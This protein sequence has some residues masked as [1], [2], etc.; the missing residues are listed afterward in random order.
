MPIKVLT[1]LIT[2][3]HLPDI[4]AFNVDNPDHQ[5]QFHRAQSRFTENFDYFIGT[6]TGGLIAFCL[7]I[8]YN[9]LDLIKIY[10]DAKH[11][12]KRNG[13][14]GPLIYSKYS[15]SVIHKKIDDIINDINFSGNRRISP[16]HA[17]LLDIRN[18]LNPGCPITAEEAASKIHQY[19]DCL[20]FADHADLQSQNEVHDLSNDSHEIQ[21]EKVLLITSYNTTNKM[22]EVF[23]TSY[24]KHWGYRIAG[25]NGE[26]DFAANSV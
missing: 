6:S 2:Q 17:T 8:K 11:Y 18:L 9:I 7:A 12:F 23:N 14:L 5:D 20:E 21:R 26:F 16:E 1:E 4:D 24:S 19:D 13:W 22:I 3:K 15:P 10:S 25:V